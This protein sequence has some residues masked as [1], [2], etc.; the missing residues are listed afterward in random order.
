MELLSQTRCFDGSLGYYRHDAETT[1]CAMRFSAFVPA[2]AA[3]GPV[4]VLWWLSGLTC[5][6]ENFTVKAGAY[7]KAAELGLMIVAPDTSPRGDGVPDDD[8]YDLGQG[9]GFYVDA[10]REPWAKNFQ[11][12]SYITAELPGVVLAE[13]PA[14]ADAQG[15]CGHSMGGHGALTLALRNPDRYR[16]LSAFAP[17]AAPTECPWGQK[18]LTA[19]LGDDRA[20]WQRYDASALMTTAGD[21][22]A[23]SEILI[24]QGGADEFL[25]AQL[26]PEKFAAACRANKQELR[27]RL[28]EGYD[29][30]YFFIATFIDDHLQHHADILWSAD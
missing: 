24:D 19:Y 14:N 10:T 1:N 15:I 7:R 29:H 13:F 5:T 30:S 25:E 26:M 8:G 9:A 4:P 16:S 18:A 20:A 11:M 28:H 12:Y 3:T 23:Y 6:E 27:L 21:R 22:S 2:Q 17:I